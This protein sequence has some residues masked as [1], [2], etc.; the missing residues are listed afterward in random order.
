MRSAVSA[1]MTVVTPGMLRT[2]ASASARTDS[3][4]L[5]SAASTLIEKNTLPSEALI[6]LSTLAWGSATP[7]GDWTLARL[8]RTCCCVT[9][10]AH[11]LQLRMPH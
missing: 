1:T 11:L 8:S 5:A 10:K 9:L 6:A 2:A 3:Q 7:R 4:A